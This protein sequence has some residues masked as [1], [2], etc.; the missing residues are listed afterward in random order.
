MVEPMRQALIGRR[1]FQKVYNLPK[2]KYNV[3]VDRLTDMN[4]AQIAYG[5][6]SEEGSRDAINIVREN[7]RLPFIWKDY[8]IKRQDL[9]S[10][11]SE[12]VS[13]ESAAAINAA[14]QLA[15]KED[16]L[17]LNGWAPKDDGAY[18][19]KGLYQAA[20]QSYTTSK[21]FATFGNAIIA[22]S[23]ARSLLW[24][25]NV[26]G[27]NFNLVI[28]P[29]QYAELDASQS[30]GFDEMQKVMRLLNPVPGA[31]PGGVYQT[32]KI[33]AGTGLLVPVDNA[34]VY[35]DLVIGAD[36]GN[37]LGIDSKHPDTSPVFGRVWES[38]YPRVKQ[39]NALATLTQI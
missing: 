36:A 12:G 1:L 39:A 25:Q 4:E 31:Y 3:D 7:F 18:V 26:N 32:T 5:M 24:G 38:A 14:I 34:G 13:L 15:A 23:G 29:T 37:E 28:N 35:F 9:E 21:D 17:L 33:T 8:E 2:G 16:D 6:P 10:Y 19:I 27:V 20:G 22:V 11:T 30:D